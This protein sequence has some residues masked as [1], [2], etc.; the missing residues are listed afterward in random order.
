MW[1]PQPMSA[2]PKDRPGANLT[3]AFSI[4]ISCMCAEFCSSAFSRAPSHLRRWRTGRDCH[5]ILL[6]VHKPWFDKN[7]SQMTESAC[8]LASRDHGFPAIQGCFLGPSI[9]EHFQAAW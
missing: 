6:G 4:S 8:V 1:L 5:T 7:S 9:P 3:D 2:C